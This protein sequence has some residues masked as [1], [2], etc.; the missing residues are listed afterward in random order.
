MPSITDTSNLKRDA[1]NSQHW[2][3]LEGN[4]CHRIK[5]VTGEGLRNTNITD[6]RKH[7]FLP[8]VTGIFKVAAKP[9]LEKWKLNRVVE[10]GMANPA[11]EQEGLETY[12]ERLSEL[13]YDPV[14]DAAKLG[15]YGHSAIDNSFAGTPVP[16]ELA[17]IVQP[18]FDWKDEK[19]LEVTQREAILI[20][21]G[22]GYAGTVDILF[23]WGEK[24]NRAAN[25]GV[26]DFKFKDTLD[27]RT[28]KPKKVFIPDDYGMQMA[29]YGVAAYGE[30]WL[31][32]PAALPA[33]VILSTTAPGRMSLHKWEECRRHY[34]GFLSL[35][36][37]WRYVNKYDPRVK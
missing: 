21:A 12:V 8:S 22:E 16:P 34:E 13:A 17:A 26:L 32:N 3:D 28:G 20:N 24:G 5:K 25:Q 18:F 4:A 33:N 15:S 35:L 27:K 6:A 23:T 37:Y 1:R 7:H 19:Q 36:G 29:A 14:S 9:Q 11:G 10:A 30:A 31:D 2:Y